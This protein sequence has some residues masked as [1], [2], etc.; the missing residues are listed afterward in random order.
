MSKFTSTSKTNPCPICGKTNGN[1]RNPQ[2][3]LVLCMSF[4]DCTEKYINGYKFIGNDKSNSWGKFLEDDGSYDR[5][6]EYARQKREEYQRYREAEEKAKLEQLKGSLSLIERDKNIKA[7]VKHLGLSETDRQKLKERGLNDEEIEKGCFATIKPFTQLPDTINTRLAGIYIGRNGKP[8]IGSNW[9][10][11]I[12]CPIF[13]FDGLITGYQIATGREESKYIW[14]V[15]SY[16]KMKRGS[17]PKISSHLPNGEL[18]INFHRCLDKNNQTLWLNDG[19]L[20]TYIA[21]LLHTIDIVGCAGGNF[22]ASLSQL[23]E[24]IKLFNYNQVIYALDAGDILNRQVMNR[25]SKLANTLLQEYDINLQFAY[26]G[27]LTKSDND[28]DEISQLEYCLLDLDKLTEIAEKEQFKAKKRAKLTEIT[29]F[30]PHKTFDSQ[31]LAEFMVNIELQKKVTGI[32]SA[33][34][35][36]KTYW[37]QILSMETNQ[38][39]ILIG[40]RKVLVCNTANVLRIDYCDEFINDE[41]IKEV[42]E[43]ENEIEHRIAIVC[44]SLLKMKDIDWHNAIILIDEAEQFLEHLLLAKTHINKIRGRVLALL[45][46]KLPTVD[47]I[48]LLDADLSDFTCEYFQQVSQ[49]PLQK[50][51]NTYQENNRDLY[52][53]EYKDSL[54]AQLNNFTSSG[55]HNLIVGDSAQELTA[56]YHLDIEKGIKSILLTR[57]NLADNK[58]LIRFLDNHGKAIRNEGIQNVYLSPVGQS[59]ISIEIDDYFDNVFGIIN[60]A[61]GTNVARQLLIRDRSKADRHIWVN[62]YG[63]GYSTDYDVE[64]ILEDQEFQ[65]T[66]L[67]NSINYH[68]QLDGIDFNNALYKIAELR[69]H[70]QDCYQINSYYRASLIA[71]NNLMKSDYSAILYDE[72]GQQGYNIIRLELLTTGNLEKVKEKK[73]ELLIKQSQRTFNA[74]EIDNSEGR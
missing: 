33:M 47:R 32:K 35:T 7:I 10:Q 63:L 57:E 40:S 46:E 56:M 34:N 6:S 42:F 15:T 28:I 50:I 2:E 53:Y 71:K 51:E 17:R 11:G 44:D 74:P 3:K 43:S 16:K 19:I 67:I 41:I 69:K 37:L 68:Q 31:Y 64:N 38:P 22:Q 60:G 73:E 54:I 8:H 12:L 27:Q 4:A 30:T 24:I 72:L 59:G 39:I 26:W 9:Q 65:E 66:S 48:V 70:K 25:L 13:N 20:K 23:L 36:G 5:N 58:K 21:H 14:A 62:E 61:I 45:A 18:P 1:C 49:L 52:G 55:Q 29:K